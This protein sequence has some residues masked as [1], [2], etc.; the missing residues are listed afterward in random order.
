M[1]TSSVMT[2]LLLHGIDHIID[3]KTQEIGFVILQT[4]LELL[5]ILKDG[6]ISPVL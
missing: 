1:N 5:P 4:V 6:Y 2:N 3:A